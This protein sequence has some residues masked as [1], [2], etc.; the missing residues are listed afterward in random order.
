MRVNAA[1]FVT[2]ETG[3]ERSVVSGTVPVVLFDDGG[4]LKTIPIGMLLASPGTGL[5]EGDR[6]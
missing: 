2:V 4:R 1:S 5:I 6:T 3:F